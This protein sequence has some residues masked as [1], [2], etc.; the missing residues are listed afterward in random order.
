MPGRGGAAGP[1]GGCSLGGWAARVQNKLRSF[2]RQIAGM[3]D[4][5]GYTA[6]LRRCHP[7]EPIPSER[8]FYADF[9]RNRYG[10]GS[11]RCC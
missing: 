6:H 4:Y 2:F 8:E 3:P 5:A 10:D 11:S 9:I 7:D 1:R